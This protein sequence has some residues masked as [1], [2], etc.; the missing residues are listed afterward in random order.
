MTHEELKILTIQFLGD[1]L[2]IENERE[3]VCECGEV[4]L[5]PEKS[6]TTLLS[7]M[8]ITSGC[9]RSIIESDGPGARLH[10]PIAESDEPPVR[11]H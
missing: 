3:K 11:L 1:M 10:A 2:R 9:V 4:I 7:I 6:L 8:S 5:D